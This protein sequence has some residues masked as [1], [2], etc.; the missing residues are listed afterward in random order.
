MIKDNQKVSCNISKKSSNANASVNKNIQTN[1]KPTR[2]TNGDIHFSDRSDFVP[3]LT[4]QEIFY[5]GSFGGTYYRPIYSCVT[6]QSYQNAWKEFPREWF[7]TDI[8]NY[9]V[10]EI[11]HPNLNKYGKKQY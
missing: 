3:N 9:V 7:P 1:I 2:S 8:D 6:G 10:S 4:P 11:C 5:L